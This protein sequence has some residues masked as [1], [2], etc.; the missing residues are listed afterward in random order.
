MTKLI[1]IQNAALGV[2]DVSETPLIIGSD[3]TPVELPEGQF[4]LCRCGLSETKPICDLSHRARGF[5]S[6]RQESPQNKKHSY[7]GTVESRQVEIAYTPMLCGHVAE[8]VRLQGAVFDPEQ[9][10]WIQVE[11]G[12]LEGLQ[13]AVKACPSGALRI[14]IDG[15][16]LRHVESDSGAGI[17]VLKDGPYAV[18]GVELLD[19][20]MIEPGA[21]PA[22]PMFNGVGASEDEYILCRCGHSQ[23]KPFCDGAHR[24]AG[25]SD[26]DE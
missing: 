23:N 17:R 20:Y 13:A 21:E 24:D 1:P 5:T 10:P 8:C 11:N 18:S 3:G 14:S 12:T 6:E 15:E 2:D 16:D 4:G 7:T 22:T 26:V 25:W 19:E 9:R